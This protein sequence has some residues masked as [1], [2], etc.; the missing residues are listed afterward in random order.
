MK[1]SPARLRSRI[2]CAPGALVA[3]MSLAAV[4]A[5][6]ADDPCRVPDAP[7]VVAVG[8]VHGSYDSLVTVLRFAGILDAKGKW[9]GG[10]AH[11]VQTGDLLDR[12]KDTRKVLDLL[13]RLEGE[14]R[15]AGGRVHALLGNHEVMNILGDLRYLN[16]EEYA[17]FRTPD[18]EALRD[19]FLRSALE[20]A[21]DN[22]RAA[23]QPFDDAAFRSKFLTEV[24]PGLVERTQALSSQGRY[25]KWLRQRPVVA[26]VNGV[27]FVHGGLTPEVAALGC[28]AINAQVRR[29]LTDDVAKTKEAPLATLAAG[30]NG[31]LWYR[32][33]AKDDESMLAPQVDQVLQ[34]IGARAVVVGHSVTGDGRIRARFGGRVFGIDVG[35]GDVYGGNLAAIE[36]GADGSVSALYPDRR[37]E[38]TPPAAAAAQISRPNSSA[39]RSRI[40][41]LTSQASATGSF[42]R[43][44]SGM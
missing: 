8:D 42:S 2:L 20:R 40:Q 18:S 14:A 11:L 32:G 12:G 22:A 41:T 3:A 34:S 44:R 17:S 19:A 43:G 39:R 33:L 29:E 35:M 7:R 15:K 13:M 38:L 26:K 28:E 30:E 27:V 21:R 25:G 24:P 31:P 9:A 23:G 6:A 4:A 37:E 5:R 16:A 1:K 10:K 36:V